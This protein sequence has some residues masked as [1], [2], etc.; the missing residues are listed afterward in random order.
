M[1]VVDKKL[2]QGGLRIHSEGLGMLG[3]VFIFYSTEQSHQ[4]VI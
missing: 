4:L 1:E 3:K 2:W